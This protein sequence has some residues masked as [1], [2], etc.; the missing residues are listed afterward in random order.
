MLIV[1]VRGK[2]RKAEVGYINLKRSY[3][4]EIK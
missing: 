1:L 4:S 2:M 3:K